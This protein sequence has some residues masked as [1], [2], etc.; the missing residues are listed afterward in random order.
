M[1]QRFFLMVLFS[2][3]LSFNYANGENSNMNSVGTDSLIIRPAGYPVI[4]TLKDTLFSIHT[5]MGASS[6]KERALRITNRIKDLF[7]DAFLVIDSITV[8]SIEN[9]VD[10]IYGETILMSISDN[11]AKW[12]NTTKEE[13]AKNYSEIIKQDLRK[14]KEDGTLLRVISRVGLLILVILAITLLF[15]L[16]NKGF[17]KVNNYIEVNK[18]RWLKNLSYKDY[19][20][21]TAEQEYKAIVFL[22]KPIRWLIYGLILYTALPAIFSIFPFTRS[23]ADTLFGLLWRPLK[24]ILISIWEYLP[25]LFSI[26]VIYLVMKY[27][28]KFVKYLFSE[29]EAEKLKISWF[30]PDWAK[31]TYSILRFLLYAFM[32]ILIF[33]YLPGSDSE[34]FKGVSVFLGVLV[35]FGSSTAI[36]NMVSGLVI[37]YMRP[38]KIGDRIKIG[39]VF[40]DVEEK[41]L[42]V[43]RIKTPKNEIITIPNSALLSGNTINYSSETVN[44]GL[45][46]HTTVTI[47][48]DVPWKKMHEIL[49]EAARRTKFLLKTPK[50]F[51]LQTSLDD[52]YVSYQINAYTK[53]V[54]RQSAIYS[55]LHQNIQDV[56]FEEGVEIMS[57][58][59]HANREGDSKAIPEIYLKHNK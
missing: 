13:L 5:K 12:Q 6:P 56:C 45:I 22:L 49:I 14:G 38:F 54:K 52:F 40:G 43:I 42:L 32:F 28:I 46:L 50:P 34:I 16:I 55:C 47:G 17:K 37:T 19:T 23:W 11:D 26:I 21:L 3:L 35:S 31:T 18:G 57:P 44:D 9:T 25:N 51:V 27:V 39:D 24:G 4:G 59:Y 1:K 36:A 8:I 30:H 7:N 41:T 53:E 48:Y 33:P 29:I 20:I 58:H 2:L 15:W 10:I